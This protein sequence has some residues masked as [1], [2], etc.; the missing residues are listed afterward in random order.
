MMFEEI[1]DVFLV[2]GRLAEAAS[3]YYKS[4]RADAVFKLGMVLFY[5]LCDFEAGVHALNK[6]KK[7]AQSKEKELI[8]ELEIF[9]IITLVDAF[10]QRIKKTGEGKI[11]MLVSKE[12][13]MILVEKE[14]SHY[15]ERQN[16]STMIPSFF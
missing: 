5:G 4:T 11:H 16:M 7:V 14:M 15:I 10:S 2:S 8:V 3:M 12:D 6:A 9:K 13:F 1:G